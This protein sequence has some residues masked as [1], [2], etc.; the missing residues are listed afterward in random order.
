MEILL[1]SALGSSSLTSVRGS[2]LL[3]SVLSSGQCPHIGLLLFQL[4]LLCTA[5]GLH[6]GALNWQ[7][8][9]TVSLGVL[10]FF[11]QQAAITASKRHCN[12]LSRSGLRGQKWVAD[13]RDEFRSHLNLLVLQHQPTNNSRQRRE[14]DTRNLIKSLHTHMSPFWFVLCLFNVHICGVA[15]FSLKQN[16]TTFSSTN[17]FTEPHT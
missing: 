7:Q 16:I 15:I 9:T 10:D 14:M 8:R 3:T 17:S 6:Q 4:D 1:T 13:K 12:A 5:L 11:H 2:S